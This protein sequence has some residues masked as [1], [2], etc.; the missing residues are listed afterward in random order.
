MKMNK[1]VITGMLAVTIVILSA[2]LLIGGGGE[3]EQ[4]DCEEEYDRAVNGSIQAEEI[5]EQCTPV[6]E[7]VERQ[8]LAQAMNS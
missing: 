7:D 4:V 3:V 2:F 1:N 8:L 5:S 6:P